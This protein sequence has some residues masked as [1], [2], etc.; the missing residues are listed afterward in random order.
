MENKGARYK[1]MVY[2]GEDSRNGLRNAVETPGPGPWRP[3]DTGTI[4]ACG[5]VV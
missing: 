5:S 3:Y 4:I 2:L 1:L